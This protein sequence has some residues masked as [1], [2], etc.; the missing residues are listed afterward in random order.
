MD[1]WLAAAGLAL[2][3]VPGPASAHPQGDDSTNCYVGVE[4]APDTTVL[5]QVVALAEEPTEK[6]MPFI[7]TDGDGDVSEKELDDYADEMALRFAPGLGFAVE[8]RS[9]RLTVGRAE[10]FLSPGRGG[11]DVLRIEVDHVAPALDEGD[12]A[13]LTDKTCSQYEGWKEVIVYATRGA[14]ISES[15]VPVFSVSGQLRDYPT[16]EVP[17]D[18]SD[19]T[20]TV[21]EMPGDPVDDEDGR[22]QSV[23]RSSSPLGA[24]LGL[25]VLGLVLYWLIRRASHGGTFS[26]R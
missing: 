17:S 16:D 25:C 9:Q 18:V 22:A 15:S 11:H 21:G 19:A 3:L 23:E 8:G 12:E 2:V 6:E 26:D 14:S 13:E 5:H 4:V 20:F 1:R 10:G 7:D 24:I